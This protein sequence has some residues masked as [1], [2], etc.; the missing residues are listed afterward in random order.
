MPR[1]N[2]TGVFPVEIELRDPE[3]GDRVAGFVT[4]LATVAPATDGT[5]L[6]EPL[7]VSWIWRITADPATA[8]DGKTRPSFLHAISATGRLSRLASAASRSGDVPLTIVP[9]PETLETWSRRAK[10]DPVANAGVLALRAAARTQQVLTG[11]Y[12]PIDMPSLER[13][14]LGEEASL[15]LNQGSVVLGEVLDQKLDARM[16][17]EAPLDPASLDRLQLGGVDRVVVNPNQLVPPEDVPQFTPARPF[18][19]QNASRATRRVP[20]RRRAHEPARWAT[21]RRR[22]APRTSSPGSRSSPSSNRTRR[23]VVAIAMP[24]RWNPET[25][26]IDAVLAGLDDNPFV[27]PVTL[28]GL[29]DRCRWSSSAAR[30]RWCAAAP[31]DPAPPRP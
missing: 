4:H 9:G 8:P 1:G 16:T 23:A 20:D 6:G 28:D 29:F 24:A 25:V 30:R 10:S 13:A 18:T 19:L 27:A 3:S 21:I 11:P 12:V 7:N 14:G 26:L 15:E 31:V 5:P 22:C 2:R 17:D